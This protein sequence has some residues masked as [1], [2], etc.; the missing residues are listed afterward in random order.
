MELKYG[1]KETYNHELDK[2]K[3]DALTLKTRRSNLQTQFLFN[4]VKGDV[5]KLVHLEEQLKNNF[6]FYCPDNES[7]L[8]HVLNLTPKTKWFK[9]DLF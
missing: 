6:L 8:N 5:D 2:E 1:K 3:L 4:L 7:E 9:I